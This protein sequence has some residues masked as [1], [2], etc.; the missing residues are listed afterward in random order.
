VRIALFTDTFFPAVNGVAN[1]V[2]RSARRLVELGHEVAV[3][4]VSHLSARALSDQ[5]G[6]GITVYALPSVNA[7]VYKDARVTYPGGFSKKFMRAFAPDVIHTHSPLLVGMEAIWSAQ[8]LQVPLVGTHHTFFDHYLKYIF[9]DY[10]WSRRL[11]W[12]GA[13]LYYNR[14]DAVI[15]P[16]RSLAEG[17]L[18]H[19]LNKEPL[20]VP[21]PV[22]LEFFAPVASPAAKAALKADLG[23]RGAALVYM[24]RVSYE[25]SIDD[26]IRMLAAVLRV[27]PDTT[28]VVIGDGPERNPLQRLAS[29]LGVSDRV[30]F[31]GCLL[32]TKL[33]EALQA[34][35]IFVLASRSENMPLAVLEAMAAGL[36]VV[37]V[38]SLGMKE[39]VR[40]GENGFLL[41][42]DRLDDMAGRVIDLI[43]DAPKR[44]RLARASRELARQYSD[45][46]SAQR[47]EGIYAGAIAARP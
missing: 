3:C 12:K 2:Y 31:T 47:L 29:T 16:T 25:K 36:P 18:A 14:C 37:S 13:V 40:D 35:D 46:A 11:T 15:S 45:L 28:L 42:P 34:S 41:L 4:T 27:K 38:A 39:I 22:D 44:E 7:L 9:L 8:A 26:V 20:I 10:A 1:T 43:E 23:I 17:L 6:S 5:I 21:N 19:G 30:I 32:G 33:V 24:G